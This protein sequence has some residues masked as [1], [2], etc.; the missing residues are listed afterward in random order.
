MP[1]MYCTNCML[2][3]NSNR[4]E[5]NMS[6]HQFSE[7]VSN[8]DSI[9]EQSGRA[10]DEI[11]NNLSE[12]EDIP[13]SNEPKDINGYSLYDWQNHGEIGWDET[14]RTYFI[15]LIFNEGELEQHGWWLGTSDEEIPDFPTLCEVL[16]K[17]FDV[18]TGLFKYIDCIRKP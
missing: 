3:I 18:P 10:F 15:Q 8:C 7:V 4:L 13:D 16:N 2:H 14:L 12:N 6:R 11:V 9:L 1:I 5:T 17:I